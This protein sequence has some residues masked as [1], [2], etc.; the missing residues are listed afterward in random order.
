MENENY[1]KMQR[2]VDYLCRKIENRSIDA[3]TIDK[4]AQ[5][6]RSVAEE[7]FPDKMELFDMIYV[8]RFNRLREQYLNAGGHNR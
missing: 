6:I 5:R 3:R 4:A 7:N 2:M 1:R 8:S